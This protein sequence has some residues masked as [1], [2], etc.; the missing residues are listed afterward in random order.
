MVFE[1]WRTEPDLAT[2]VMWCERRG[3]SVFVPEVD[4]DDMWAVPGRVEPASL[5]LVVVPGLAFAADG[6]R[7]GRGGGHYDRFLAATGA[8]CRWV[9][10]GFAEQLVDDVPVARHDV[11]LHAVV[12]DA[13][14]PA[15]SRR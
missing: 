9:G 13:T 5:D 10:V 8:H 3:D 6:R 2:F 12:T 14:A 7:L 11:R 4:G 15:G 1:P